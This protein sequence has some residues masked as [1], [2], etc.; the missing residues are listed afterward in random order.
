M[1]TY[2]NDAGY[3]GVSK[4]TVEKTIFGYWK[5]SKVIN[6][7]LITRQYSGYSKRDAIAMFREDTRG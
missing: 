1:T 2:G 7:V 6:G 5:I 4:M 3:M